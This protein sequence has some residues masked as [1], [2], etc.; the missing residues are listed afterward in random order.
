[1]VKINPLIGFKIPTFKIFDSL[2]EKYAVSKKMKKT[3][4]IKI[5]HKKVY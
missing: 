1:M 3:W 5:E 4:K 2:D